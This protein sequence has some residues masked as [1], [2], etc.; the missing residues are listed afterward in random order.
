MLTG[1]QQVTALILIDQGRPLLPIT[2]FWFDTSTLSDPAFHDRPFRVD[3][4][5]GDPIG[6]HNLALAVV[7]HFTWKGAGG[8]TRFLTVSL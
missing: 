3:W 6:I 1:H 4:V 8:Q 7:D 5:G 2:V